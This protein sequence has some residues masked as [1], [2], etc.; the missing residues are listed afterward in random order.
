V[1]LLV[2]RCSRAAADFDCRA[3]H[4]TGCL[5]AGRALFY[6][7]REDGGHRGCVVISRGAC[8]NIGR[9]FELR[10]DQIAEVTRIAL[11]PGHLAPVSMV[12]AVVVRLVRKSNPGLELLVSY[13]DQRQGHH[14]GV[15]QAAGWTY[16]GE[17]AREA[18]L[19]VQG[20]EMHARTVSGKFGTRDLGWLRTHVDPNAARVDCPPKHKYAL[21]LTA[22]MRE[23][24]ATLSKP[25]PTRLKKQDPAQSPA[26]LDGAIPIRPLL[27]SEDAHG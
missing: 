18:T 15:Y 20:R 23:R 24:L 14:G 22:T 1:T 11:R 2:A 12:L 9:P 3:Y 26:G 27:L 8:A 19:W 25:Y 17:T 4:Y 21:A 13:A 7:A 16:L 6:G 10:Q 5:P